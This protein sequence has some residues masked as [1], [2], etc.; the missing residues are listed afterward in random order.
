MI[1][2]KNW[3]KY[4]IGFVTCFTIRLIPFSKRFGWLGGFLFGFLIIL[5]FDI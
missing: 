5:L 4:A 2:A 3:A 1:T